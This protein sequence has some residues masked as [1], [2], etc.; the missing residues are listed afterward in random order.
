M[1]GTVPIYASQWFTLEEGRALCYRDAN[2]TYVKEHA[3]FKELLG[4]E[5]IMWRMVLTW[6]PAG[7]W[8]HSIVNYVFNRTVLSDGFS[9]LSVPMELFNFGLDDL[10]LGRYDVEIETQN[11]G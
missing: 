1:S 3:G 2:R 8:Q 5:P 11:H 4:G 9:A 6:N 7:N 10:P